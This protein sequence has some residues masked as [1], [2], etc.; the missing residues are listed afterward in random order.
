MNNQ[1]ASPRVTIICGLFSVAMGMMIV[2][3]GSGVISETR[4]AG[5]APPWVAFVGGLIFVLAGVSIIAGALQGVPASGELP[6]NATWWARLFYYLVGLTL[7]AAL[8]TIGTWVAFGAGERSFQ[9]PGMFFLSK[10]VNDLVG[11]IVF[12]FG[13]LLTWLMLLAFAV[14]SG[15]KLFPGKSGASEKKG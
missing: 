7:V 11:R 14:Y 6:K 9:G 10:S 12:G 8:A 5:D 4:H 15:R 3:F 1:P 13:A 2:L